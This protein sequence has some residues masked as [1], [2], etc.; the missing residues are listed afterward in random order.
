MA[1]LCGM[2]KLLVV[3]VLLSFSSVWLTLTNFLT[4]DL[5]LTVKSSGMKQSKF[6]KQIQLRFGVIMVFFFIIR[7]IAS[8]VDLSESV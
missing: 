4:T 1:L 7:K 5:G 3:A 2:P 6:S 8:E